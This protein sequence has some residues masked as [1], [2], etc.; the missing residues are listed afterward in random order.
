[1]FVISL[2]SQYSIRTKGIRTSELELESAGGIMFP[3]DSADHPFLSSRIPP[4]S[5]V[6]V[7]D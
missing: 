4:Q 5:E 1:M 2:P 3:L 6:L 7:P